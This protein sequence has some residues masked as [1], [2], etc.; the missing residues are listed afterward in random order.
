MYTLKII[1]KSDSA[2]GDLIPQITTHATM[3]EAITIAKEHRAHVRTIAKINSWDIWSD[4]SI[5]VSPSEHF[6]WMKLVLFV[7][8]MFGKKRISL[9]YEINKVDCGMPRPE[10]R[11][12][13]VE[14]EPIKVDVNVEKIAKEVRKENEKIKKKTTKKKKKRVP[15]SETPIAKG[16]SLYEKRELLTTTGS[17]TK[18]VENEL[19]IGSP[20]VYHY[21]KLYEYVM[22]RG[23]F[24]KNRLSNI[25][26]NWSKLMAFLTLSDNQK[27]MMIDN[28]NI[29]S[30]STSKKFEEYCDYL[31]K[32][33]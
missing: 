2:L 25:I 28:V 16:K 6:Q 9:S 17:W 24:V 32:N 29:M 30:N 3:K 20:Q 22:N 13:I 8:K 12:E 11:I 21:I 7:P 4:G 5:G 14:P 31:K 26:N 15:F 1:K 18:Y 19:E 33:I 27:Q 10:S 23:T